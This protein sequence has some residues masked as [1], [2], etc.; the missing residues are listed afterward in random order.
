ML[1]RK[2]GMFNDI[3]QAPI[4]F[5]RASCAILWVHTGG[6]TGS[7]RVT[8]E[9]DAGKTRV[10]L[11]NCVRLTNPVWLTNRGKRW[12]CDRRFFSILLIL[13]GIATGLPRIAPLSEARAAAAGGADAHSPILPQAELNQLITEAQGWLAD[14]IR[15]DTTNPPGNELA[16]AK[17]VAA[18]LQKENI[19]GRSF[20]D[21]SRAA[22]WPSRNCRPGRCAIPRRRCC[23]W[24]TSTWSAWIRANG[25]WI[26]LA[27]P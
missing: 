27:P 11:A 23:W 2:A 19:P 4:D 14:L 17:Y 16:A 24:R 13:A 21:R 3:R 15:I 20:G 7:A 1:P 18:V 8:I 26:H 25:P 5:L 12:R 22:A 9:F 10:R 6:C